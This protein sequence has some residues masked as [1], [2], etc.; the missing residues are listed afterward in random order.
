MR[1]LFILILGL[2]ISCSKS[3]N[4]TTI[5]FSTQSDSALF[6]Y[7]KGWQQIMDYGD[8]SGAEKSY[9]KALSFDKDFLVAQSVLAR[10]TLDVDERWAIYKTLENQENELIG[11]ERL[12]MDVYMAL[13]K[14]TN[15]RDQD[16]PRASEALQKAL[17]LG[18]RNL[19]KIVHTY[20]DEVY[21]KAEYAEILHSL[22]GSAQTLDSLEVIATDEQLNNPFILGFRARLNA[23]L[24]NFD[25]ALMQARKLAEFLENEDVAKSDAVYADVYFKMG[26]LEKAMFHANHAYQAD[27][28][29]LDASRLKEKIDEALQQR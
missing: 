15:L 21:I 9:R 13:V 23:E 1:I 6:Y 2:L 14:Y 22:Y 19:R 27:P 10:L 24:K 16:S 3:T 7:D 11:D 5:Q 20:P 26:E 8:Y 18:E 29:N 25:K 28:R 4:Q 12:L 17:R